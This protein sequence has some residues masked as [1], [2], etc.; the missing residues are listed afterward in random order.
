MTRPTIATYT[1]GTFPTP[2]VR[3]HRIERVLDVGPLYVKRDDLSGFGMAGNKT[4]PLQYLIADALGAGSDV[5]VCGGRA[6]SNFCAAAAAAARAAGLDCALVIASASGALERGANL[7]LARLAGASITWVQASGDEIDTA[8]LEHADQLA[9]AGR[10][11]YATPRGGSTPLGAMGFADAAG[12][13]TGQLTAAGI[14]DA[15]MVCALGSGG[16]CAGLL[17]GRADVM[18]SWRLIAVS[19]SRPVAALTDH[20]AELTEGCALLRGCGAPDPADLTLVDATDLP[21]GVMSTAQ[22][23]L[24]LIAYRHEGLLLEAT[25]TAK[26]FEVAVRHATENRDRPTVFWHTGGLL[27]AMRELSPPQDDDG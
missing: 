25:Y 15:T 7:R 16:S 6:E 2:L 17:V 21:H 8:I 18:A 23:E 14:A 5:F 1:L 3:L 26:A 4:R 20:L 22:R 11:P 24:A 9:A 10:R 27:A 19:V 12:E 13:I